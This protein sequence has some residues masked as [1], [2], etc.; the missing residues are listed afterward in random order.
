MTPRHSFGVVAMWEQHE[1]GRVG[2]E[3]CYTGMQ[4]LADNLY[5]STSKPYLHVGLLGEVVLGRYRL[6][7]KLENHLNVR[8]TREDAV[9]H[10]NRRPDGGWTVDAWAPLEGFIANAGIRVFLGR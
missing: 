10:P 4:P 2:L 9:L 6:F 3:L 8:Q 7:L 5:R 1:Q